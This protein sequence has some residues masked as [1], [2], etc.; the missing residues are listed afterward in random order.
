MGPEEE[1]GMT[2]PLLQG[3][4]TSHPQK[5]A[6]QGR[7]MTRREQLR[8]ALGCREW[9]GARVV[10]TRTKN[11]S[12]VYVPRATATTNRSRQDGRFK[13]MNKDFLSI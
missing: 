8:A 4:M 13:G 3:A 10:N 7:V 9:A 1:E 2:N 11:P 12:R 6:P 5:G